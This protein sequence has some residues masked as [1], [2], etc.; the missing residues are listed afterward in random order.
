MTPPHHPGRRRYRLGRRQAAVDRT[1]A[2]ILQAARAVLV[3][4]SSAAFSIGAVAR[5]ARVTRATVYQRFGSRPKLLEALF[6]DLARQGGMWDL[7]L[8]FRQENPEAALARFIATFGRFWTVHRPIIQRLFALSALDPAL[9]RAL[10]ARNEWR[11]QGLREIVRRLPG[12]RAR[13]G[14]LDDPI[15]V[16]FTLTSFPFFDTL[17]GPDRA[18]SSVVPHVLRAARQVLGLARRRV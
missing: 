15:D 4:P 8:A 1:R 2:R 16:L 3:A 5:R 9:G 7:G 18:P 14:A 17:A 10:R 6:D 13:R 11:R 12:H